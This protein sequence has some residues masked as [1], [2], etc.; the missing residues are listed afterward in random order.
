MMEVCFAEIL[1]TIKVAFF[2]FLMEILAPQAKNEAD[3]PPIDPQP[4]RPSSP[5]NARASEDEN[6]SS[7]S[8][9][10]ATPPPDQPFKPIPSASTVQ[11]GKGKAKMYP[12]P[13]LPHDENVQVDNSDS[14]DDHFPEPMTQTTPILDPTYASLVSN[15]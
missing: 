1:P 14:P 15:Q 2:T 8:E 9:E 4:S 10:S 7:S 11:K 3:D 12:S 5:P 6:M 13:P